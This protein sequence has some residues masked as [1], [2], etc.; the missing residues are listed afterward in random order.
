MSDSP[1]PQHSSPL[2][3]PGRVRKR[4]QI[5][6][7][8]RRHFDAQGFVE[9][10]TPIAM[11]APAP[12][13]HIEAPLLSLRLGDGPPV[14]RY[15]QPSP[16]LPM[17]RLLATGLDR[18]YQ[19]AA[20][21]RDGDHGPH[22]RPE[23]R[24]LEWYRKNAPWDVLLDDCESLITE[25]AHAAGHPRNIPYQ[26][27]V[28]ELHRPFKRLTVEQAFS[29]YL[30]FSILDAHSPTLLRAALRRADIHHRRTDSWEELFH[31]AWLSRIEPRLCEAPRPVFVTHY[32]ASLSALSRI[33]P[34]DPRVCERFE[35]FMGGLELANGFGE[36]VDSR[37]QRARFIR[38]RTHRRQLGMH[39][40][41]LDERFLA[42]L[43]EIDSAAGIALGIDRLL[44]LLLDLNDIDEAWCLPWDQS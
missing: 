37:Q 32:P 33:D 20:V 42:A 14:T 31:R 18:I 26:G 30:G 19:V 25:A 5:I 44:M 34:Q 15:L 17:K 6:A 2:T 4:A 28:L 12:E 10:D 27:K 8:L 43:D 11:T 38:D 7:A 9:V 40:Y 39:D 23:F 22:H 36:L 3:L 35:L 41:P 13:P 29:E 24:L 16:E 21:F 1:A